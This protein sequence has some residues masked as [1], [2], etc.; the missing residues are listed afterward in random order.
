MLRYLAGYGASALV[1]L[2]LDGLW[3]GVLAR[4]TYEVEFGALLRQQPNMIAAV[5]FYALYL[6]GVQVFAVL[7][8]A[9]HGS[10]QRALILGAMLGLVAYATYDLTNLATL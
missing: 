1:F 10:W 8:G 9:E 3:L 4:K 6:L 2:L 5:L 7:P